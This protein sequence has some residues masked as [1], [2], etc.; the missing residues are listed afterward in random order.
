MKRALFLCLLPLPALAQTD[1]R[2]YLTAFLEDNLSGAGRQV[3][4]SGFEGALSSQ[5]RI[6]EITIADGAGVWL[7]L[8]DVVLDW[9]RSALLAGNVS[10]NELSAGE[11]ILARRPVSED[12]KAQPESGSFS[13]PEL[14]VSVDIGR[15]AAER[16]LL[17]PDVLGQ[18]VEG[19][20]E[21]ALTLSGGIGDA[22]L[23]L[24]RR[25]EG[26]EGRITLTA[27]YSNETQLLALDLSASEAAGGLVATAL[28]LPG[29]PAAALQVHGTGPASDFIA[30]VSLATDGQPRL[31]GRVVTKSG[32]GET[33]FAANVSGDVAPL[34][35]PDYAEF[36]GNRVEVLG[37]GTA[38]ADGRLNFS[39][40]NLKAK[41]L[42]LAGSLSLAA[43][44]SPNRF[45]LQGRLAQ[46]DGAAVLLPLSAAQPIR[47][48]S[49]D[50]S[51]SY[52]KSKGEG[53]TA[54]IVAYGLDR[55][56]FRASALDLT[57]S[58]RITPDLFGATV[59][60]I[61][62][63]LEPRDAATA[64]ALGSFVAGDAVLYYHKGEGGL[65]IPKLR[66]QGEDYNASATGARV[67]G[68][69]DALTLTGKV[70]AELEDL[71]RFAPLAKAPLEGAA[72]AE[73]TGS[74][75]P[76]TGA[77][78]LATRTVGQDLRSG[79]IL[80]DR[81]LTGQTEV[82]GH[83]RRDQSGTRLTDGKILGNG[84]DAGVSG[85][86]SSTASDLT[87]QVQMPDLSVLGPGFGG[88]LQANAQLK[89]PLS[90]AAITATATGQSLRVGNA[91][92]NK[93]LAGESQMNV[94]LTLRDGAVQINRATL[95]NP[96][97][98]ADISGRADGS[99]QR[100]TLQ[101]KLRNLGV[102][103]P[104]FPGAL[105]ANGTVQRDS[106]GTTVDVASKGPGGIDATIKGRLGPTDN[107]LTIR[108]RA[109]AALANAFIVPR[110]IVGPVAF[111]L[112][113][114]GPLALSSLSG[115]ITLERGRLSDPSLA[116]AF[117]GISARAN[118]SGGQARVA[119]TLPLTTTGK[120]AV[121]G[122]I[123]LAEPFSA[124]LGITVQGVTIRDPDLFE[125]L[126]NGELDLTGPVLSRP[127]L[128][129]RVTLVETE[130]RIPSTGFG[131]AAG[132]P[133]LRHIN[134]PADVRA[135]RAR[136][137]LL[138]GATGAGRAGRGDL[139]LDV[140]IS[141]PN[142]VFVRGRGLDAELGGEVRLLGTLSALA[143][144]GAFNLIRG[145]LDLLGKRFDLQEALLQLE[146]DLVP[147][148]RM[149]AST[150]NDG[151]TT[152]VVIE[153]RADDPEVSFTSVPDM[154]EE[155]VLAQ[156][157]F[158][159]DLQ[160][161]SPMQ[162]L[163]LA[164]AV[165]TL[166]GRGGQGVMGKLRQGIG[167]D[168][169]DVKTTTEGGAELTAGKYIGKNAY[170]EVTVGQDGKSQINL[171]LDLTDSITLRGR[172]DNDGQTGIGVFLEKDY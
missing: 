39:R 7:T 110:A 19:R 155:E 120:L 137:G 101:A 125:T 96:E 24:E 164:N 133:E 170:T 1:D 40:V 18:P 62:E 12:T 92:I 148:L 67:A 139:A 86:I 142:R 107:D 122:T 31:K 22:N 115:P 172:A 6:A 50:V 152:N 52:D 57:A 41:A 153:G 109:Q 11:I 162:A 25:D 158:G 42:D 60:F 90:G 95:Q 94:D 21:A 144:A 104:D 65:A 113:L 146:G 123:G 145:R 38:Y 3:V 166:A 129:G 2:G 87:A 143:P 5:A 30:D 46:K 118:L 16:I 131:G 20:L 134:E 75:S 138:A 102:L 112:K 34:F 167:V 35:L 17:G 169:L 111:D 151:I 63:G 47:I 69:A 73:V 71:S 135:T 70:S 76:L 116:F 97:I 149:V 168:N 43:N 82:S 141:A 81:L 161:L 29:R 84:V 165:A 160:N 68:L 14:P 8:H 72:K 159:Q 78:D 77:F 37:S 45:E 117:D 28:D 121:A 59:A 132:L 4:I 99:E 88:A 66:L 128:A 150:E 140:T 44:G 91:E 108:G 48:Q 105:T 32:R 130:L 54:K 114:T 93:L 80:L 74:F 61:G 98:S 103:V 156:L 58:G 56:D 23:V 154:P 85:V 100:L 83:L 15:I 51:V 119:A 53:W 33:G 147:F 136:A 157:L 36:F 27:S 126:M 64:R 26:P 9:N 10:V 55:D 13:L 106:N 89:G 163:Q 79:Q 127:L 49:G 171:N 124:A